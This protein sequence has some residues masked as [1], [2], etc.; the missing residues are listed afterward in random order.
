M[1]SSS[2]KIPY[3][4]IKAQ[5]QEERNELLPIIDRILASGQYVGGSES[6]NLKKKLLNIVRLNMPLLSTVVQMLLLWLTFTWS[7]AW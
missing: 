2:I 5:W 6:I 7:K 4:N 1:P 3:V